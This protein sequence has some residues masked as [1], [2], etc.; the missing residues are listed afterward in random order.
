MHTMCL[1]QSASNIKK[2]PAMLR[3]K[4]QRKLGC[5]HD[6]YLYEDMFLNQTEYC[7][8]TKYVVVFLIG[9]DNR[10]LAEVSLNC[11]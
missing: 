7:C 6:N 10:E 2:M 9:R 1:H 5:L 4:A 11:R 8:T 3:R